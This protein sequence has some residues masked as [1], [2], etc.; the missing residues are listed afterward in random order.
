MNTNGTWL[1]ELLDRVVRNGEVPYQANRKAV[2]AFDILNER[3]EGKQ[4]LIVML[5]G[6]D[7]FISSMEAFE[8]ATE[9]VAKQAAQAA[10]R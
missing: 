3:A 5:E 8:H 9:T 10:S 7:L 6:L 2:E 1:S 4:Q